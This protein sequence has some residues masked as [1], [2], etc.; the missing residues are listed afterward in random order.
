M[1]ENQL[2]ARLFQESDF[3]LQNKM[4]QGGVF[5]K[6]NLFSVLERANDTT[7]FDITT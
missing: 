5:Y 4:T 1:R 2:V 6:K 3:L 7:T